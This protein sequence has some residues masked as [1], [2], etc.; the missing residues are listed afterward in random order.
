MKFFTTFDVKP[1]GW[2]KRQ[3]TIQAN[4]LNGNLD[5][6][7]PDVKESKWIGGDR[8]GWERVPYWLDGFVP[9]AF[10]L[11]D[12]DMQ[13]RAKKYID[14]IIEKQCEDGWLCPCEENE[15][16]N[17][18]MW[19][20]YIILKSLIVW[21]ECTNDERIIDV[22]YKALQ[23]AYAHFRVSTPFDWAASRW[24]EIIIP[25]RFI[26]ERRPEEWLFDM[27]EH[28]KATGIDYTKPLK[29]WEKV[30]YKTWSYS[31]HVVN[32]AMALKANAL[33]DSFTTGEKVNGEVA[34]NL[35]K[36][37]FAKHGTA[38]GHFSGDEC[39]AGL[40]PIAGT[41]LCGVV[42]A[43]YS[44]EHLLTL[45]GESRWG[46]RLEYLAFNALP[47]TISEDMWTHQY[48][49]LVNQ[50]ACYEIESVHYTTNDSESNVFGLEPNYGCCT[51]NFGQGFPKLA[52]SAFMYEDNSIYSSALLPTTLNTK[53]N[54]KDVKIELKTDYP[55]N[56][57][58][59]YTLDGGAFDFI[60]R[61]P[62]FVESFT[63]NGKQKTAKDGWY[64][65]SK[66]WNNDKLEIVFNYTPKLI[67]RPNNMYALRYGALLFA[68]QLKD[69]FVKKE[70]VKN[71]VERKFPYCDY[72]IYPCEDWGFAFN[73]VDFDDTVDTQNVPFEV[74]Y[75]SEYVNAFS[76]TNPPITIN[77][78]VNKIEWGVKD[79]TSYICDDYPT[80]VAPTS[81]TFIRE[82]VPY[83]CTYLRMTE[84][85]VI[86][87]K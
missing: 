2:L 41:E 9:L 61:I 79:G 15:R 68:V 54:G 16:G 45:T 73:L 32:T 40:S 21:Y 12:K 74:K 78:P 27:L 84:I 82:F 47:A 75:N 71:D 14:N 48:D 28:I 11:D 59:T 36:F 81:T 52:L 55:F 37:L 4:G 17:Y 53:F 72:D 60:V 62:D 65:L 5:K 6:F 76:R 87:N 29:L 70:Y 33:Y 1:N 46:D 13:S 18:D 57:V 64:K 39:L 43:M 20:L 69:R 83:G 26:Y 23:K 67:K 63:V 30:Q 66:E 24:Y 22:V 80:N 7:W 56:N 10:L 51:A 86:K 35:L 42:E 58:L 44:Y 19:G 49:Q 77:V 85:P 8:E 38:T 50:S 31:T 3:L 25:I 34:E